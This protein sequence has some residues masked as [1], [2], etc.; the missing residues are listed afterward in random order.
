MENESSHN[1]LVP[2]NNP[3]ENLDITIKGLRKAQ[4]IAEWVYSSTYRRN[5]ITINDKNEEEVNIEDIT[6][7]I[8]FGAELGISAMK[9]IM[10]GRELNKNS[11]FAIQRGR[12][13]NLD[14]TTALQN[15][16]AFQGKNGKTLIYT[17]V[18]IVN[19]CILDAGVDI[20]WINDYDTIYK[21]FN[22]KGEE[23]DINN[24]SESDYYIVTKDSKPEHLHSAVSSGKLVLTRKIDKL[25]AAI[26]KRKGRTNV[27]I[28]FYLSEAI[29]AGLYRGVNSFGEQVDGKD[30]WNKYPNRMMRNRVLIYIGRELASDKLYDTYLPD[31]AKVIN[32]DINVIDTDYEDLTNK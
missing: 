5:F 8:L 6:Y 11:Y 20:E 31:E 22:P 23:V 3:E 9:S 24:K 14:E 17:G 4:E 12:A 32:P 26:G 13:M 30:N 19:K 7:C 25:T 1:N 10:L 27:T 28:K 2:V 18:H 29:E 21:Y 16:H 15:I